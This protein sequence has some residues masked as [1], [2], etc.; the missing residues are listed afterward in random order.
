MKEAEEVWDSVANEAHMLTGNNSI[1]QHTNL[2]AGLIG[3]T[4]DQGAEKADQVGD[5]VR[6]QSFDSDFVMF[7]ETPEPPT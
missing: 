1:S 5:Y 2:V 3:E 4:Y 6:D 7:G